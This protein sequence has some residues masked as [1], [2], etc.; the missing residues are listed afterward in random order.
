MTKPKANPEITRDDPKN[1]G[2]FSMTTE[3]P[4]IPEQQEPARDP[5][6]IFNDLNRL[7]Q[8]PRLTVSRSKLLTNCPVRRPDDQEYFMVHP[9]E[10]SCLPRA[11]VIRSKSNRD[12]YYYVTPEME[13]HPKLERKF[14]YC[15]IY[16]CSTW[17]AQTPL[18]YPVPEATNFAAWRS[19]QAAV[20]VG[21]QRWVQIAW[22]GNDF[23]V[24]PAEGV[25]VEPVWPAENFGQLLKIG[26]AGKIIDNANHE[27]MLQLRGLVE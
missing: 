2:G 3:Q 9:D 15:T 6:D 18:L 23:V 11:A 26:F 22:K 16:L 12:V 10:K 1:Q 24:E 8:E 13:R 25:D 19:Q 5:G 14:N 4:K 21:K 17:P 7:R 20:Q 27:F